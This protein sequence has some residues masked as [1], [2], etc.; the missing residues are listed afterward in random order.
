M[1]YGVEILIDTIKLHS[2]ITMRTSENHI[3]LNTKSV[4]ILIK[5]WLQRRASPNLENAP[6]LC[7]WVL[8]AIRCFRNQSEKGTSCLHCPMFCVSLKR[9]NTSI[10][11]HIFIN[12]IIKN[13]I[14]RNIGKYVWIRQVFYLS[15]WNEGCTF[16][17]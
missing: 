13:L 17:G 16:Y 12:Y 11:K 6:T 1:A 8:P 7:K 5:W 14:Y 10:T 9:Y 15:Y 3:T 2:I 4:W